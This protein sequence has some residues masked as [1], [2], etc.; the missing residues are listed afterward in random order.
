MARAKTLTRDA[1]ASLGADRL[2]R[3]LMELADAE[4]DIAKRLRLSMAAAEGPEAVAKQVRKRFA[5]LRRS[6]KFLDWNQTRPLARELG[7]LRDVITGDIAPDAPGLALDLLWEFLVL[8]EPTHERCDDSNGDIGVQFKFA[9]DA[10]GELAGHVKPD[11]TR[12]SGQVFEAIQNNGYGQY[13]GLIGALGPALGATG[14]AHLKASVEALAEQPVETPPE[15][16]REVIG[17]SSSGPVYRDTI[18]RSSRDMTVRLALADIADASGDVDAFVATLNEA[19]RKLPR[20]AVDMAARYLAADRAG[21]ALAALEAVAPDRLAF[22]GGD[23]DA[24]KIAVLDHL[25]RSDEAQALRWGAFEARLETG[26]LREYL[27][28]LP[29]FENDEAERAALAHAANFPSAHA[30]LSFLASW[31]ALREAAAVAETRLNEID[32]EDFVRLPAAA[33]ALETK[34]PLAATLIRRKLVMFALEA[35]RTKRYRHAAR[36]FRECAGLA[37]DIADWKGHVDH[38][39]WLADLKA[40]HA[41]KSGFWTHL[42]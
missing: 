6:T 21:E 16:E 25:G 10:I 42:E 32:G 41:R 12:L 1:L 22:A 13:D 23:V 40:K 27:K 7:D 38:D 28:R 36:S 5:A 18:E 30:A 19:S 31:P 14:L 17:W 24:M 26:A 11:P 35:A 37:G 33:E 34:Q 3:L 8:A 4:P 15:D 20:V 9:M 2:A 29:D 39:T